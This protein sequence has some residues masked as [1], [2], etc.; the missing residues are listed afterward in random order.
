MKGEMKKSPTIFDLFQKMMPFDGD[1]LCSL[2]PT[3]AMGYDNT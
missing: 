3:F 1:V 2:S